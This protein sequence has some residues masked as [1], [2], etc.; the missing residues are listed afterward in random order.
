M[1]MLLFFFVAI[2]L[3]TIEVLHISIS[4]LTLRT[5]LSQILWLSIL[6]FFNV[7]VVVVIVIRRTRLSISRGDRSPRFTSS[8]L[9][10]KKASHRH[11]KRANVL[12]L[13]DFVIPAAMPCDLF[14]SCVRLLFY[15]FMDAASPL[16]I[17]GVPTVHFAVAYQD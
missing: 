15:T 7:W 12:K 6:I 4:S 8:A 2:F 9:N 17:P 14:H 5:S 10:L 11:C 16:P 13:P 1:I 3:R